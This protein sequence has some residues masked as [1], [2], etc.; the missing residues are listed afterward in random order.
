M[1]DPN[2]DD[3]P[4]F[5]L[6]DGVELPDAL[7]NR[8]VQS[9]QNRG[10]LQEN[11]APSSPRIRRF[12]P[13]WLLAA[14]AAGLLIGSLF[15]VVERGVSPKAPTHLLV[16]HGS[17]NDR[18]VAPDEIMRRVQEY[19][20]WASNQGQSGELLS[21]EKLANAGKSLRFS[22][23]QIETGPLGSGVDGSQIEGFFLLD[24]K[25]LAR[26]MNVAK[27]CPHLQYGGWIELRE[28]DR[29]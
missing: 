16:L 9:L 26:A 12:H 8:T 1:T 22:N 20:V 3:T 4:L 23:D 21:G 7:S 29:R 11:P 14:S 13:G 24:T 19:T 27:T 25:D 10:L 6:Q 18:N 15:P 17:N 2:E 5:S 28:I